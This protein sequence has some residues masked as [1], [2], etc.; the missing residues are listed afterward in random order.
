MLGLRRECRRDGSSLKNASQQEN[1]V[2][3][4]VGQGEENASRERAKGGWV[5]KR[6]W[7]SP[8]RTTEIGDKT[9]VRSQY[10]QESML[11]V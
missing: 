2:P 8:C 4:K 10:V 1:F 7:V 5:V 6:N 11:F 3:K 9:E